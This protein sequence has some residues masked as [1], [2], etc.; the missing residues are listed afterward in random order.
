LPSAIACIASVLFTEEIGQILFDRQIA[1]VGTALLML[2]G[3]WVNEAHTAQQNNA[4]VAIELLGIWA[5]LQVAARST[6]LSSSPHGLTIQANVPRSIQVHRFADK[7]FCLGAEYFTPASDSNTDARN[8]TRVAID[9]KNRWRS[10][11][12]NNCLKH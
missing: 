1:W 4:L 5:L 3:L 10:I 2:M 6:S 11:I 9:S 8:V 12:I 7:F